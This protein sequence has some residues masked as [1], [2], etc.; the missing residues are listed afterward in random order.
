MFF[1]RLKQVHPGVSRRIGI[2][3][4]KPYIERSSVAGVEKIFGD[5]RE[6][7]SLVPSDAM[8]CAIFVD[9]LEH[10]TDE[11]AADLMP[12]VMRRFNRV[13]LFIPNGDRE[14]SKD[15]FGLGADSLQTHRS[16]WTPEKVSGLGFTEVIATGDSIYAAWNTNASRS[17][18][19]DGSAREW[20]DKV[21]L[22]EW[23]GNESILDKWS[24]F[25]PRGK[26]VLEIGFGSGH[27][28]EQCAAAG[29]SELYGIEV[30]SGAVCAAVNRFEP[31]KIPIRLVLVP[32]EDPETILPEIDL[33]YSYTVF[34]HVDPET[35]ESYL[36]LVARKLSERGMGYFQF[37]SRQERGPLLT[38]SAVTAMAGMA[39][40]AI[41]KAETRYFD[42]DQFYITTKKGA[43]K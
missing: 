29:A 35:V 9:S 21:W 39:G 20:S 5:M 40:L 3:L 6:F 11:D 8:D 36:S 22:H 37:Y 19:C 14:Q 4:W 30:S 43:A 34:Q 28:L 24:G 2:E 15:V 27:F 41:V 17:I 26:R 32:Q 13:V 7:E 10:L 1:D 12:R 25:D 16:Y 31:L 33:A 23:T 42:G 38:I 18:Y